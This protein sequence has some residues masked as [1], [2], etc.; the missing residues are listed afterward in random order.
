MKQKLSIDELITHMKNKGI[1]FDIVSEQDA[2]KFLTYNNY[3]LKL[4]SYRANYDKCSENSQRK[5]QYQNLD[6]GYLKE[7][8]TIDMHLR[9][10]IIE[11]CL[12]IEHFI[13]VRL[14][15]AVTDTP[16]EDGYNVVKKY[17]KKEDPKFYILKTIHKHKSGEYCK[18]LI[19]KYYP[20]FPIWVLVELISFGDLLH[21]CRFYEKENNCTL[22]ANNKFMNTVRDFRNAAA[23][24]NC[25]MNKM[26]ER[27]EATK[28]PDIK[29][30][31]FIKQFQ[32]ISKQSRA[33]YLNMTFTYNIVTLLYVYNELVPIDAKRNRFKELCT[34]VNS[35]V[36]RHK[37]YFYNN[38]KICGT[39]SFLKKVIDNL[40][41]S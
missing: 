13:K 23:H 29:I 39:Y 11:M 6:F 31:Q 7:L 41:E 33:K 24:S 36:V 9:Y 10:I 22:I 2:R 5:G 1:K 15:S 20:Y 32:G 26:T 34:F 14:V 12:D 8:S 3:Y 35:R 18:N 30:S 17:L 21:I 38:P 37:E 25:L 4:A 16:D 27:M 19:E 40:S 28:Q